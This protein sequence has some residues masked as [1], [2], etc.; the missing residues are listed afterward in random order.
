MKRKIYFTIHESSWDSVVGTVNRLWCGWPRNYASQ[1]LARKEDFS[2]FRYV[3]NGS[4]VHLASYSVGI[5][6][7]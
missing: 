2:L 3:Q 1:F 7:S 6:D 5:R 4:A